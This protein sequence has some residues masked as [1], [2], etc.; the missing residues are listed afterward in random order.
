M[1]RAAEVITPDRAEAAALT[2]R[3]DTSELWPAIAADELL[4][5]AGARR[6]VVKTG[7]TGAVFA[8]ADGVVQVPTLSI[9]PRD[10]TGAGDVFIAALAVRRSEGAGWHESVRF[11]NIASA[12]S[13]ADDGLLL[14]TREA[15][16]AAAGPTGR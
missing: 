8:D 14:P 12:L 16:E 9:E 2:G 10:E 5:A 11:A 13:V 6:V 1:M 7:G 3:A 15:I 4:R